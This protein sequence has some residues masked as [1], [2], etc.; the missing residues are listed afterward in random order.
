MLSHSFILPF[1]FIC[2][3]FAST[4]HTLSSFDPQCGTVAG[5]NCRPAFQ[6]AFAA[7]SSAGGG[8]LQLPAANLFIDFP[9]VSNDQT[10]GVPLVRSKLLVVPSNTAIVGATTP[11]GAPATTIQWAITSVPIFLFNKSDN[12]SLSNIH[13]VFVGSQPTYYPY[14]DVYLLK[15][16]GYAPTFPHWNQMS[17]GNMELFAFIYEFDSDGCSYSNVFAESATKDNLHVMNLLVNLKGKGVISSNGGGLADLSSGNIISNVTV[18]DSLGAILV[19]GQAGLTITDVS[20]D[21]RGS[22]T[23]TAPGH[24]IY[25]TIQNIFDSA[26]NVV[27]GVN[28]TDLVIE[29]IEEG[30]NTY[31]N[32]VSGGTLAVKGVSGGVINNIVSSH[33]EGLIQTIYATQN[34]L[35]SNMTWTS[36]YDLCGNV[37]SNC[38]TPVIYSTASSAPYQP[39]KNLT[40]QN[41]VIKSSITPTNVVLMGDNLQVQGLSMQVPP[42]FLPNQTATNSVLNVKGSNG[43]LIMDYSYSPVLASYDPA[44][45]YNTAFMGWGTCTN[46]TAH[47]TVNW[48]SRLPTPS[49]TA[50]VLA[51]GFQ[52]Q[53]ATSN[54]AVTETL[55]TY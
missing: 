35:F 22:L 15:A 46:V 36:D 38:I 24:L 37:P 20:S 53:S 25:I 49:A 34:V 4:T 41:V 44:G 52:F 51:A 31:S 11:D 2:P 1:L 13:A 54:D 55:V 26:S 21:W 17:G 14:G 45:K 27:Q 7:L 32:I 28:S 9:D 16:L 47:V 3:L 5:Y 19:S 40:F 50:K 29:N 30:P 10:W 42:L 43:G 6:A 39:I 12:S 33:P 48:P 8:T 18:R 23:N